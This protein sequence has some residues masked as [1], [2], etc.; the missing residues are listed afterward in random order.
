VPSADNA[1][2]ES[3]PSAGE[4]LIS[5]DRNVRFMFNYLHGDVARQISATN[6]GNAD[7]NFDADADRIL[8]LR[9]LLNQNGSSYGCSHC[10][11]LHVRFLSQYPASARWKAAPDGPRP[12]PSTYRSSDAGSRRLP[13]ACIRPRRHLGIDLTDHEIVVLKR[14]ELLGQH[15]L[16]NSQASAAAPQSAGCWLADG[17]GMTP[18]HLPS[19]GSSVASTAHPGRW[20][21]FRR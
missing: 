1:S 16:G 21:K 2:V 10:L 3:R 6:A 18:F 8:Q 7:S 9:F 12:R 13:T 15:A 19:I 17:T 20:A 14:A 11:R 5:L 4:R